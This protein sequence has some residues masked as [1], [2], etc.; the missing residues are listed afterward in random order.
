MTQSEPSLTIT[1]CEPLKDFSHEQV[2]FTEIKMTVTDMSKEMVDETNL[3]T[4]R[5]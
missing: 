5:H 2:S 3:R 4:F 1:L